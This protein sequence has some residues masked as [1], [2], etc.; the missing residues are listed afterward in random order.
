MK[1][2]S[3]SIGSYGAT[4]SI[5]EI[6]ITGSV[7]QIGIIGHRGQPGVPG[8]NREDFL[9]ENF[10]CKKDFGFIKQGTH[11]RAKHY[12]S[13]IGSHHLKSLDDNM[14]FDVSEKDMSEYFI[15]GPDLRDRIIGDILNFESI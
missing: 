4:G 13:Y 15:F 11:F 8:I 6:G 7:G 12:H 10:Y 9:E 14:R 1:N 3:Y 2:S 5:S